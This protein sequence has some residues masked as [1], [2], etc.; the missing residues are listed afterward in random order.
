[1]R[2]QARLARVQAAECDGADERPGRSAHVTT[3]NH[4]QRDAAFELHGEVGHK[5]GRTNGD[6]QANRGQDEAG[7]QD[8]VRRP[9]GRDRCGLECERDADLCADVVAER[10]EQRGADCGFRVIL[11]KS[12]LGIPPESTPGEGA[13]SLAAVSLEETVG[14]SSGPDGFWID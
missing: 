10:D 2:V 4:R 11:R 9:Q 12:R 3:K 8:G 13:S 5:S 7:E 14:I 6:P 1:M